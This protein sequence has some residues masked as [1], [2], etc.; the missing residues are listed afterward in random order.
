MSDDKKQL[1]TK[2]GVELKTHVAEIRRKRQRVKF[3]GPRLR[4]QVEQ[5]LKDPN[6][7]YRWFND[8][9]DQLQ[10]A[11]RAGYVFV[12]KKEMEEADSAVG[13]KE[14]HGGN[15]DLNSFTSR[16]V[17]RD[18]ANKPLRAYL[19]KLPMEIYVEDRKQHELEANMPIDNA[20]R[21][22][23]PPGAPMVQNAYGVNVSYKHGE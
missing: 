14:V 21:A 16:V 23:K 20:L 4:L 15:T 19:M 11:E 9:D 7:F 22:G 13:D 1:E 10:R 17:G 3:S 8:D 18:R 5:S 12:T 2:A 6:Y